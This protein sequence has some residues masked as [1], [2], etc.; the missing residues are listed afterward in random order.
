MS[1]GSP[2]LPTHS[3]S[4]RLRPFR[5]RAIGIAA[6]R[7]TL[8]ACGLL[9]ITIGAAMWL[10]II[11]ELPSEARWFITRPGVLLAVALTLGAVVWRSLSI[12]DEQVASRIDDS[13]STGG[14]VLA[15]WQ[16]ATRPTQPAGELSRSLAAI[17]AERAGTLVSTIS[18]SRVMSAEV[19]KQAAMFSM[20]TLAAIGLACLI[21][22]EIVSHQFNRFLYPS[23]DIPQYT[24]IYIDLELAQDSVLYGQDVNVAARVSRDVERV[25][26]F[27]RSSDGKEAAIPML[28]N[29]ESVWQAILTRITEP[30]EV[31]ARSGSTR[32]KV[33]HL[34]VQ[35]TP[36]LLPPI[37]T[38]SAPAYTRRGVYRGTVPEQGLVG[39]VGTQVHWEVTSNRPLSEGRIQLSL[40]DG[41]TEQIE[42]KPAPSSSQPIAADAVTNSASET[43]NADV[44]SVAAIDSAEPEEQDI[45]QLKLVTGEM[46]LEKSGQFKLSVVDIDGIESHETLEG[47]ITILADSRP[48]VRITQPQPVSLATPDVNLPVTVI[49]EDDFGITSMALYRSLNGSP[50]SRIT[51]EVNGTARQQVGWTLPLP[52][53][54]LVPGD[55][56]QLFAR[57]EDNDPAGA[58]GAESPVTVI[59]IISVEEFHRMMVQRR[60]AESLQAKYQE[61]RR[62][63]DQLAAALK[64]VEAAAEHPDSPDAAEKLQEKLAEAKRIAEEASKAI[65]ELS[66]KAMPIDVDQELSKRLGEMAKQ[67]GKM[68]DQLGAMQQP[69][70]ADPAAPDASS[71]KQ[72]SEQQMQQPKD[73]ISQ[74]SEAQ[75]KLTDQA[76]NP[77][78]QMQ[79]MMPLII[80]QQRF[81]Q[82]AQQ[83]RD[84]ANRLNSLKENEDTAN[85]TESQR[86]VAELEGEQEQLR[87]GLDSLLDDIERGA[88]ELP[89][90]PELE[91]LRQT[92]LDFADAVRNSEAAA[93]MSGAQQNLLNT[94]FTDAQQ[95][96]VNAAKILE[97]FLSKCEGMGVKA[98]QNCKAKFNPSAG[99]ASLGN[100]IE[101]MLTMM[102]M[103]PGSSGMKPGGSPGMGMGWGAGGGFAQRFPG[104]QNVGMYGSLPM[105]MHQPSRGRGDSSSGGVSANHLTETPGQGLAESETVAAGNASGQSLSNIPSQY[106]SQVAEYF[107][108]LTEE[109]GR[110]ETNEGKR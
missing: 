38:I 16:L 72:L 71:E 93:Q 86:R 56:I 91:E 62:Y 109:L 32:S 104:Q 66:Q 59:K 21:I 101:Q 40:E 63:F 35:M 108:T 43:V 79:K 45:E 110:Q 5:N 37:V 81:T 7:F 27:V 55:E 99:G 107:R 48:I 61:A 92:A 28:A 3:I 69:P 29:G 19:V 2:V 36:Q 53:F 52:K 100:S 26:L 10:D 31:Y 95:N 103:K 82:L 50:A 88:Q 25:T 80:A 77:L 73:M 102:G 42:L 9:L 57:T 8:L 34:D 98:C 44:E 13:Q 96:A 87:Q 15:G 33:L 84:L 76:I 90:D 4:E 1:A 60:G 78:Q 6:S 83:Q 75:Q 67:A 106:R 74:A 54:A 51:A 49:A 47:A 23:S 14:E 46:R 24:G 85:S 11:W 41:T 30:L 94:K 105:A 65:E 70:A 17:A 68:S 22:P 39:L 89:D 18:P 12:T 64:E 58:K 20:G 97:S